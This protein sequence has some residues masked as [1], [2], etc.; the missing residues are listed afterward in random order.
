MIERFETLT[1][2][3]FA[4]LKDSLSLITVLIAGADGKI[5]EKELEWAEKIS[6][7]RTYSSKN[8]SE[9]YQEV[10]KDFREKIHYVIAQAP[11]GVEARNEKLSGMLSKLNPILQK[12]DPEIAYEMY[13]SLTSFAEHI[14]KASGG[15]FRFFSISSEE[16]NLM[17]LPMIDPIP[18][19]EEPEEEA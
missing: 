1:E 17:K 18:E 19:P 7:I 13:K 6:D 9:F 10:D 4:T 12:L 8:L 2:E 14:A 11:H 15:F 5:D 16:K 3:E